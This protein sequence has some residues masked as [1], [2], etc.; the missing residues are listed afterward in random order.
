MIE[1]SDA[2]RSPIL[3]QGLDR[4]IHLLKRY[5]PYKDLA[6]TLKYDANLDMNSVN[7]RVITENAWHTSSEASSSTKSRSRHWGHTRISNR[8][9]SRNMPPAYPSGPAHQVT[10]VA[11]RGHAA[12]DQAAWCAGASL[13][14][15]RVT[16]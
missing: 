14:G 15:P 5:V 3:D 1:L 11:G 8:P 16:E 4:A 12:V 13:P 6:L 9:G 2:L 7:Y 10:T